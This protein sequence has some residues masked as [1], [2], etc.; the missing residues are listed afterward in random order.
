MATGVTTGIQGWSATGTEVTA[1]Y[2]GMATVVAPPAWSEY[3]LS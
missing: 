2:R 1:V 3:S